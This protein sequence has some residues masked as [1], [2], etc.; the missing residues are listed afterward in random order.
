MI[1]TFLRGFAASTALLVLVSAS[2]SAQMASGSRFGANAGLTMPMGDFG[3]AVG[4]GFQLGGHFQ[5]PLGE[6]LKLRLNADWSTFSG[7]DGTGIDNVTL[8]GGVA[9]IV[10]PITTK[11]ALK[12]YLLGGLGFYQWTVNLNGGGSGD[13]SDLAFNVGAGYDWGERLFTE[14]RYLSIQSEGSSTNTLPITIGI[15]F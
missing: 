5:M 6:K 2:A 7:E 14:I 9:N 15:R 1:R 3:D 4:I 11:S 12:P 8:L 13:E 10:L